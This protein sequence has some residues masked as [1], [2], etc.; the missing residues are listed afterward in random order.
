MPTIDL[1]PF[2]HGF[3]QW[4]LGSKRLLQNFHF[5]AAFHEL[6]WA[7]LAASHAP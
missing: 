6:L 3:C 2:I 7:L 4:F 5:A 1:T